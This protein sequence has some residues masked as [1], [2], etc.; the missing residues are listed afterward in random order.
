M[1]LTAS[2][3]VLISSTQ[4]FPH[5]S[6]LLESRVGT[7]LTELLSGHYDFGRV[8]LSTPTVICALCMLP[9]AAD[10]WRGGGL[11]GAKGFDMAVHKCEAS[12]TH[13]SSHELLYKEEEE[14]QHQHQ[15]GEEEKQ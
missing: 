9:M 5:S 3:E 4:S 15:A 14:R 1:V 7:N 2:G 12:F 6:C 13:V 11:R 10:R 8:F